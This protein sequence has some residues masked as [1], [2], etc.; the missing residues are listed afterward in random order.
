MDIV[1]AA[2]NLRF[3]AESLAQITGRG[4]ADVE[5]VLGVVFEKYAPSVLRD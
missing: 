1:T 4:G 5:D 3:A 2:E